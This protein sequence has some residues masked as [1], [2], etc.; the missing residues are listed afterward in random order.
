MDPEQA[1][2]SAALRISPEVREALADITKNP[3]SDPVCLPPSSRWLPKCL[4]TH[5]TRRHARRRLDLAHARALL[6]PPARPAGDPPQIESR[7]SPARYLG[8]VS[9]DFS[10]A[11]EKFVEKGGVAGRLATPKQKRA[12]LNLM[13]KKYQHWSVPPFCQPPCRD[14]KRQLPPDSPVEAPVGDPSLI[15]PE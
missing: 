3:S 15:L 11:L 5:V 9:E 1:A 8:A 12:F 6:C 4:A 14:G 7:L 2:T 10:Q 13:F